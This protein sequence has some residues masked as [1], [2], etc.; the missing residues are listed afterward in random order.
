MIIKTLPY[1]NTCAWNTDKQ[2]TVRKSVPPGWQMP[3]GLPCW[4]EGYHDHLRRDSWI[5][6]QGLRWKSDTNLKAQTLDI[7]LTC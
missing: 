5:Y 7:S 4:C 3:N 6:F 1:A 2:E